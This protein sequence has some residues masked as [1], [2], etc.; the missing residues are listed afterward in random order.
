VTSIS[1][2]LVPLLSKTILLLSPVIEG[3]KPAHS[4]SD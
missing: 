4:D 2:V 1:M 3:I